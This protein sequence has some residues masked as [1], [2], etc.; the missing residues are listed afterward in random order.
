MRDSFRASGT[1]WKWIAVLF[2]IHI[3]TFV[4]LIIVPDR[5]NLLPFSLGS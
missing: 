5:F 3:P 4:T 2:G 1:S